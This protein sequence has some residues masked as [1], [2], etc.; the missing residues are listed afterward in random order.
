[1]NMDRKIIGVM[2]VPRYGPLMTAGCIMSTFNAHG[3]LVRMHTGAFWE[4]QIQNVLEDVIKEGYTDAIIMDY[5]SAFSQ[6]QFNYMLSRWIH[7]HWI[8]SLS[9]IQPRRGDGAAML[10]IDSEESGKIELKSTAKPSFKC[11]TAHFGLTF[12]RLDKL[13]AMA[14]P[15]FHSNPSESGSWRN[16]SGKVDADIYF[17]RKWEASGNNLYVLPEINL[18]HFEELVAQHNPKTGKVMHRYAQD[19]SNDP[20]GKE[21]VEVIPK[22]E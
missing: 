9:C 1:M 21:V 18:G 15:W 7:N 3:I 11:K 5:D 6:E 8:D 12:I 17:W 16:D 20:F 14:L 2:S 4:Q 22:G 19:F 13:K 10:S